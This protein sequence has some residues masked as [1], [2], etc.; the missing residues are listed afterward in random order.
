VGL[1]IDEGDGPSTSCE[2][3]SEAIVVLP[4]SKVEIAGFANIETA[5]SATEDVDDPHP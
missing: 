2:P 5:V 1:G 4:Q 3:A